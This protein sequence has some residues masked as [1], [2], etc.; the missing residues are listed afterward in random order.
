M[1]TSST[2]RS[3]SSGG[4]APG[5]S[6]R[7]HSTA[8]VK[9][10]VFTKLI[11]ILT[12]LLLAVVVTE[13]I[14]ACFNLSPV[15]D[16]KFWILL[17]IF[18]LIPMGISRLRKQSFGE[19]IWKIERV[20]ESRTQVVSA[21][22]SSGIFLT[23]LLI[24]IGYGLFKFKIARAPEW[25]STPP[26]AIDAVLPPSN[27]RVLAFHYTLAAWPP[28]RAY[29]IPYEFG[30]PKRFVGKVEA[31]WSSNKA[32]AVD[33]NSDVE[34]HYASEKLV[35]EGPKTPQIFASGEVTRKDLKDCVL[36]APSFHCAWTR[37]LAIKRPLRRNA[38]TR[39][40][41]F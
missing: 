39:L 41:A 34:S 25:T 36:G 7:G 32:S 4:N 12:D 28:P 20:G 19:W 31:L 38:Q 13:I 9:P 29:F 23:L 21:A 2:T 30:P 18:W 3:S 33:S 24:F 35:F 11:A 1:T 26:M 22:N 37:E 14:Y 5:P 10:S 8:T 6:V 17:I 15:P 16:S 40:F 27:W